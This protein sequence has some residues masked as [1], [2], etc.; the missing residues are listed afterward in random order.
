MEDNEQLFF[1]VPI[2]DLINWNPAITFSVFI[3]LRTE[4]YVLI[5]SPESGIDSPRLHRY[6]KHTNEVFIKKEEQEEFE[7]FTKTTP[8]VLKQEDPEAKK[9]ISEQK[10]AIVSALEAA[11]SSNL[12]KILMPKS[13]TS[14]EIEE[15]KKIVKTYIT[16][17]SRDP[18]FTFDILAKINE[19]D[20]LSY[21]SL[22][23]SMLSIFI[24]RLT[25]QFSPKLLEIVGLGG[26]LHDIGK[27]RLLAG[28]EISGYEALQELGDLIRIHPEN[29]LS[30]VK[31]TK[32]VPEEVKQII[33]QHHERQNGLGYPMGLK[34]PRIYYPAGLVSVANTFANYIGKK[35][36]GLELEPRDAIRKML[37]QDGWFNKPIIKILT[38]LYQV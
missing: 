32:A 35:P 10:K 27:I 15:S 11:T 24:C 9:D 37:D 25:K 13:V 26:L 23:T 3:K 21:H 8:K 31:E 6:T 18:N 12:K 30:M 22:A 38:Q 20:Y 14:E 4:K 7:K 28:Q 34:G 29:G 33:A 17:L 19:S 2:T 1:S 5:F 16:V 36:F